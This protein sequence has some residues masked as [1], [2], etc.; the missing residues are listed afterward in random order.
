MTRW[1][2]QKRR[3]ENGIRSFLNLDT[4]QVAVFNPELVGK[5]HFEQET[6]IDMDDVRKEGEDFPRA[7]F[8][9]QYIIGANEFSYG[10]AAEDVSE[11]LANFYDDAI[12]YDKIT[13]IFEI[14]HDGKYNEVELPV[15]P[16]ET[17]G[18]VSFTP[19]ERKV[20]D[21][22]MNDE[23]VSDYGWESKSAAAWVKGFHK[24]CD[25]E[26]KV[27]SAVVSSLCKKG[28]MWTNGESFGLTD[29]GRKSITTND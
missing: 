1:L 22:W 17:E 6:G 14:D 28:I 10:T 2:E 18:M 11:A 8:Q 9:I 20:L 29:L 26:G 12:E 7:N 3:K 21:A 24:V 19:L 27:F 13:V 4:F 16:L 25:M 15:R 23:N 5:D